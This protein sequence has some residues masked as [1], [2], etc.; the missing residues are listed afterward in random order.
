MMIGPARPFSL[1]AMPRR[2]ATA[3]QL[4]WRTLAVLSVLLV[5]WLA[6][7]MTLRLT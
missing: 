5:V 4:V 3:D 6:L 7:T 2:Q 1:A